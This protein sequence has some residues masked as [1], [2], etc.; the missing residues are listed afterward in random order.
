MYL[1]LLSHLAYFAIYFWPRSNQVSSPLIP[2]LSPLLSLSLYHLLLSD[3]IPSAIFQFPPAICIMEKEDGG[4][5]LTKLAD[6]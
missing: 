4:R 3:F 2:A 1:F 5:G 6:Q